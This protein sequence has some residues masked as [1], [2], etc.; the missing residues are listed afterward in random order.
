M[1]WTQNSSESYYLENSYRFI[2]SIIIKMFSKSNIWITFFVTRTSP[3][4]WVHLDYYRPNNWMS[5][6]FWNRYRSFWH[7]FS[8]SLCLWNFRPFKLRTGIFRF[9]SKFDFWIIWYTLEIFLMTPSNHLVQKKDTC[10]SFSWSVIN[11]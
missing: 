7:F 11:P 10:L 6:A 9:Y 8:L 3:L 4:F 1:S 2:W 5:N